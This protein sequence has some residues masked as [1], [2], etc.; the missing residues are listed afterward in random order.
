MSGGL[1][2]LTMPG[3][4]V[5]ILVESYLICT[6]VIESM[7]SAKEEI[8]EKKHKEEEV[9]R[10]ILHTDDKNHIYEELMKH[11]H[12]PKTTSLS[13]Y[14]IIKGKVANTYVNVQEALKLRNSS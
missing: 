7:Y 1:K 8:K 13:F 9:K 10:R 3:D 14:N 11:S 2:G 12:P 5:A 4:Q 6:Y